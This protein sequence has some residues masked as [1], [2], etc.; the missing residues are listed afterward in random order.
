MQLAISVLGEVKVAR[1]GKVLGLP[2]PGKRARCWF[3][4]P[5]QR[6][7]IDGTACARCSGIGPTIRAVRCARA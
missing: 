6:G 3:I 4:W 5:S 2:R 7:R 1:G